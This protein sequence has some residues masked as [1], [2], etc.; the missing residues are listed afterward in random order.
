M[1]GQNGR[2][3]VG[4]GQFGERVKNSWDKSCGGKMP[5][6]PAFCR[7]AE[8]GYSGINDTDFLRQRKKFFEEKLASINEML[9]ARE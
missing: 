2:R 4:R 8:R 5:H 7:C 3:M 1:Y 6:G 9:S